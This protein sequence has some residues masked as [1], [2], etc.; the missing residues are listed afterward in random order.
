M[1]ILLLLLLVSRTA[2]G[3]DFD[4]DGIADEADN[5][6]YVYN[7]NQSDSGGVL[8]PYPDGIGNACQCGD[9]DE[10]GRPDVGDVARLSR[11][12]S[13][14]GP[15][16]LSPE[17]C[18]VGSST[19]C[20]PGDLARLREALAGISPGLEQVCAAAFEPPICGDELAEAAEPCDGSDLWGESC[21]SLGHDSGTLGCTTACARDATDCSPSLL[22]IAVGDSIVADYAPGEVAAAAAQGWMYALPLYFATGHLVWADHARSGTSTKSFRELGYWAAALAAGPRWILIQ[23]GHNDSR[24]ESAVHTDPDTTYRANLHAMVLEARAIGAEPVFVTPPPNF[25]AAED[26]LHVRRPN[27]LEGYVS[28]MRAQASDDGVAVVEL[29]PT[30]MDDYD[31]L[32]IQLARAL[33]SYEVSPGVPD[34]SHFSRKGAIHAAETIVSQ[35]ASASPSLAAY[36]LTAP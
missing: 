24:L 20:G 18:E 16:L 8:T 23:F 21:E 6:P 1:R 7:W 9:T 31:Q 4:E 26:G 36:L 10:T 25:I 29:H 5:C 28:A 17:K 34:L 13:T 2:S 3:A 30:L 14:L 35:L 15:G 22:A 33:Y 19:P 32:G 12:L 11:V 27:G